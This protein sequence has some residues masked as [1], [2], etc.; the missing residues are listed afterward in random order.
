M[1]N[2]MKAVDSLMLLEQAE[3]S[4]NHIAL[5]GIEPNQLN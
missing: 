4:D 1:E 2:S 3:P 5:L